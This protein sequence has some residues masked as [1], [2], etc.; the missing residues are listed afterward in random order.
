MIS[1]KNLTK[2]YGE[3]TALDNITFNVEKGEIVGL[4]GP[5][6]AGKTTTMRIL[7]GYFPPTSGEVIIAG[8]N[9]AEDSLYIRK[10]TGYLPESAPL[11]SDMT[12]DEFLDFAAEAKGLNGKTK[13][14]SKDNAINNCNLQDYAFKQ[15]KTLSKG[16]KQRVGLA[17]AIINSPQILILDEPTVGLDPQQIKDMR[18]IITNLSKKSTIILS[19]HILE[20]ISKTCNRVIIMNKGK[21]LA[22]DTPDNLS[23]KIEKSDRLFFELG[24]YKE[25]ALNI[26]KQTKGITECGYSNLNLNEEN[27]F[28]IEALSEKSPEIR[29]VIIKE[30]IAKD[31]SVYQIKL[32]KLTL[33]QIFSAI[34]EEAKQTK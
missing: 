22:T 33:E 1:V 10:N 9:V 31:I 34:V 16:Y 30:L 5:N 28:G 17:Q 8:K 29:N 21:V 7:T 4:L 19:S 14:E 18:E 15:L 23:S 26:I 12:V 13:R 20:E 32:E 3:T 27:S 6:A 25:T 2:K 24:G 11:Y